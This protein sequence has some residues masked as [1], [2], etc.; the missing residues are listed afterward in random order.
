MKTFEFIFAMLVLN[1]ILTLVLK[2]SVYLQSHTTN[3]DDVIESF[4]ILKLEDRRMDL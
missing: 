2:V 3:I 4:K 1:P